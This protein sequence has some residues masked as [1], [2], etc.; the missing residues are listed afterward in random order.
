MDMQIT[1]QMENYKLKEKVAAMEA[2]LA[3]KVLQRPPAFLGR[4]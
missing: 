2:A 4:L 3:T 1:S